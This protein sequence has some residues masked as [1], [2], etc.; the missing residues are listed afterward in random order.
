MWADKILVIDGGKL[1]GIGKHDEL[2]K[3]CK[4]YEDILI[5][6]FGKENI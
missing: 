3:T 6:Q 1:I 5:S 4:T 2:V